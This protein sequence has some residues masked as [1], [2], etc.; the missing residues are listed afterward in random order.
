MGE[1]PSP[2]DDLPQ[3]VIQRLNGIGSVDHLANLGRIAKKWRQALPVP[4]PARD[5]RRLPLTS[6]FGQCPPA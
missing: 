4:L 1:G 3:T 5:N 2:L 6:M